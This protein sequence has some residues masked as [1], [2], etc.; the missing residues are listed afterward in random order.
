MFIAA[1]FT[2]A[3]TW[4]QVKCL[5]ITDW[6]KK[7]WHI[8]TMEYY[9]AIKKDEFISFSGTWMKLETII[10]SKLTKAQKT[11]HCMFSFISGCWTMRTH[12]QRGKG[13]SHPRACQGLGGRGVI[14]LGEILN[15]LRD[16]VTTRPALQELLKEAL[17]IERN[18]QY[19]PFQNHT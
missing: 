15:V 16:F 3:R 18:N 17:H 2:I 10:F 14:A 13:T 7:M 19:Q 8:D 12:G 9:V 6:I 5:W 1:L 4:N 11:K